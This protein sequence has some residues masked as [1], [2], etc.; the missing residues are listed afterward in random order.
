MDAINLVIGAVLFVIVMIVLV[1]NSQRISDLKN[2][3]KNSAVEVSTTVAHGLLARDSNGNYVPKTC[4]YVNVAEGTVTLNENKHEVDAVSISFDDL[5]NK[6]G[7][8]LATDIVEGRCKVVY[9]PEKRILYR[10]VSYQLGTGTQTQVTNPDDDTF[11]YVGQDFTGNSDHT[12]P[13]ILTLAKN[14]GNGDAPMF[15]PS[16]KGSDKK[17]TIIGVQSSMSGNSV[18]GV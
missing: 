11:S 4:Y 5:S 16:E 8:R 7:K 15:T 3:V 2:S 9:R 17:R 12:S 1:T 10:V 13:I 18:S 6:D 14:S